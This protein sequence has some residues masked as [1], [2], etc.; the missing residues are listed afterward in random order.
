M[1]PQ[2]A[3]LDSLRTLSWFVSYRRLSSQFQFSLSAVT[4]EYLSQW[5]ALIAI[6]LACLVAHWNSCGGS[7]KWVTILP[8][9]VRTVLLL[10]AICFFIPSFVHQQL[11]SLDCQHFVHHN[12]LA[13]FYLSRDL[14]WCTVT[15]LKGDLQFTKLFQNTICTGVCKFKCTEKRFILLPPS[16]FSLNLSLIQNLKEALNMP[17]GMYCIIHLSEIMH[18]SAFKSPL[19]YPSS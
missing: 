8:I 9:L 10:F 17:L 15:F 3:T 4:L 12:S 11:H 6:S 14:S 19:F 13:F 7:W 18:L 16:I 1:T 5:L 2:K